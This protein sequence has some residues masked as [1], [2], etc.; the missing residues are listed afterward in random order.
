MDKNHKNYL[1][2]YIVCYDIYIIIKKIMWK[3]ANSHGRKTTMNI[4][5]FYVKDNL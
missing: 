2:N 4:L 1:Q 3:T 5:K